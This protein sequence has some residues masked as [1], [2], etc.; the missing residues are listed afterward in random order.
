MAS[1]DGFGVDLTE[2]AYTVK[3]SLVRDRYRVYDEDG[4]LLLRADHRDFTARREFSF[5]DEDGNDVFSV[6]TGNVEDDYFIVPRGQDRPLAIVE[7]DISLLHRQWNVRHGHN[8][9]LLAVIKAQGPMVEFFRSYVPMMGMLPHTYVI[10]DTDGGRVGKLSRQFHI[11]D[12]YDIDIGDAESV[13]K[14]TIVAAA[15]TVDALD[16]Y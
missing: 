12:T 6:R 3:Q 14:E 2:D 9:R 4:E 11:T 5:V 15:I 1:A 8:E 16:E 10:E 7:R 13:P